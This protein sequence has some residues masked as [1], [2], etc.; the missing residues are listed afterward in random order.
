MKIIKIAL[1][2][3]LSFASI[4]AYGKCQKCQDKGFYYEVIECPLCEGYANVSPAWFD[5]NTGET[6]WTETT[7]WT[8]LQTE[9]NKRHKMF[10]F[11][12]CPC[13]GHSQKKGAV[14]SAMF[15]DCSAELQ[16][17]AIASAKSKIKN[18]LSRCKL[19]KEEATD[20][21][22]G[23]SD[24]DIVKLSVEMQ[25]WSANGKTFIKLMLAAIKGEYDHESVHYQR[26]ETQYK[27]KK[28]RK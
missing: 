8:G 1:F 27:T 12:N 3:L 2:L 24:T 16:K 14:K 21:L 22:N 4:L 6:R 17:T 7:Y 9:S 18:G 25:N 20:L 19:G 23:M 5:K 10:S 13:C 11:L 15:C 28:F 26:D